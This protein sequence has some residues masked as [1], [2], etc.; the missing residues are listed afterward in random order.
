MANE[1]QLA[2][3]KQG[4]YAW[5]LWRDEN[6]HIRPDLS[7]VDLGGARLMGANFVAV[8]LC[9]TNLSGTDL[10]GAH[11][12]EADLSGVKFVFADLSWAE[13]DGANVERAE[14]G[15]TVFGDIDLSMVKGLETVVHDGPSIIGIDT[16]YRSK[17]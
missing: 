1:E 14:I 4:A 7:D 10:R 9:M 3:I 12:Q 13:L 15:A 8:N 2:I 11:F 17:G 16:I 6:P 5:H